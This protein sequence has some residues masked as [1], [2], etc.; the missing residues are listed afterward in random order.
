M[1]A[2]AFSLAPLQGITDYHFRNLFNQH[3][4]G[5]E[6]VYTPFI[7]LQNDKTIKKSQIADILPVN[8][9]TL[10]VVPQILTNTVDEFIY[11]AKYISDLGYTEMNWNL[12]CP[13]PMVVKRQMGSGLL[14]FHDRIEE[15]L[16]KVMPLIACNLS[17]KM[18]AGYQ[19]DTDILNVIPVLN[20][21]PITEIIIHPR[22]GTQMYKGEANPDIVENCLEISIHKIAYNGDIR[23]AE[24]FHILEDR[25]QKINS[26][27]IGRA[28]ISNPFLI[29]ELN[30]GIKTAASKKMER[31]S[32]FHH[33]LFKSYEQSLSGQGHLLIKMIGLWEYFSESFSNSK[34]VFK[35]IN[36]VQ[37]INHYHAAIHE[38]FNS[39]VF[40]A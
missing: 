21:F 14:P 33:A 28:A 39:E 34:K 1:N 7:R 15:I 22:V 19:N 40:D 37:S 9:N 25:F 36:K 17:I 5:L 20:Q 2:N 24:T 8:N 32:E 10:K 38:I 11:M 26:W 18:R 16:N 29:E 31:F 35:R 27:M 4:K 12:G 3:F 23:S 6:A 30:S 13:F